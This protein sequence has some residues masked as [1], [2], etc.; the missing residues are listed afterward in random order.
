V[1]SNAY[2]AWVGSRVGLA[3]TYFKAGR[4]YLG[5]VENLRCRLAGFAYTA[6]FEGVLDLIEQDGFLLRAAYPE[7]SGLG[8]IAWALGSI[9]PSLIKRGGERVMPRGVPARQRPLREL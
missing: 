7:R 8:A 5:Q 6:R 1:G 3:R 4:E 2:R 9:F